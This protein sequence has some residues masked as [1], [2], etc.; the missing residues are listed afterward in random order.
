MQQGPVQIILE[1]INIRVTARL[2]RNI[3]PVDL[4]KWRG[5]NLI[6]EREVLRPFTLTALAKIR[7]EYTQREPQTRMFTEHSSLLHNSVSL[8]P[9]YEFRIEAVLQRER[10]TVRHFLV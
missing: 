8:A 6:V 3:T 5:C 10:L 9:L 2:S 7:L 4:L 1:T